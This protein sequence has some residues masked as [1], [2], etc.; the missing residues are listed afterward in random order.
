MTPVILESPY[1]GDIETNLRYARACMKDCLVRQEA[2]L[3][4]HLLYTQPGILDD[5]NIIERQ[6]GIDAGLIW[7]SFAAKT[8]VYTD[9]GISTGMLYGIN[10]A[11]KN[12]RPIEY[13]RLASWE[14]L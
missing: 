9:L 12:N 4:S 13:R 1:A 8:I 6:L 14:T 5:S 7:G 2:P 10:H 3:A 11:I